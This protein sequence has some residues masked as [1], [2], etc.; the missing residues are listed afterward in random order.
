MSLEP[1][2]VHALLAL[3]REAKTGV[4]E[5]HSEGATTRIYLDRGEVV[6]ADDGE[7]AAVPQERLSEPM[8]AAL[9][10]DVRA[11]ILRC[12]LAEKAEWWMIV[13]EKRLEGT[14]RTPTPL[15]PLVLAAAREFDDARIHEL[16]RPGGDRFPVLLGEPASVA[17]TF[18]MTTEERT[19]LYLLDGSHSMMAL[20]A[21]QAQG[22]RARPLLAAL[23][24]TEALAVGQSV[25]VRGTPPTSAKVAPPT[26]PP[27]AVRPRPPPVP[28]R[29]PRRPSSEAVP[30]RAPP[31]DEDAVHGALTVPAPPLSPDPAEEEAASNET[32]M[33]VI[34]PPKEPARPAQPS[35][36]VVLPVRSALVPL[37]AAAAIALLGG[38]G[39]VRWRMV[40]HESSERPKVA[41]AQTGSVVS[42][43]APPPPEPTAALE[44]AAPSEPTAPPEQA[45]SSA[46][47]PTPTSGIL[48]SPAGADGHRI[49]V[50]G[51]LV[52]QAPITVSLSCGSHV[53]RVG[54]HGRPRR[55]DV[56]CG[57]EVTASR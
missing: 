29:P 8:L 31:D 49:F 24:L 56:P 18:R 2:L 1:D 30:A 35:E 21:V 48:S 55:I 51:K 13:S 45:P 42:A 14:P 47:A 44:L 20:L 4:L 19:F 40:A 6:F 34:T 17:A 41:S 10:D 3:R 46:E 54:S 36:P 57:G 15:E 32:P 9:S 43:S 23:V 50:D 39:I 22:V 12:L 53:V 28:P 25:L 11:K 38:V 27:G 7:S 52:G 5:V 16:L 37:A 26:P 33:P